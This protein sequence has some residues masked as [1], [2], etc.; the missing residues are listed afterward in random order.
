MVLFCHKTVALRTKM[1]YCCAD[2]KVST[3][4]MN[5]NQFQFYLNRQMALT[6][7]VANC[8]FVSV[9]ECVLHWRRV[10]LWFNER[11]H[12]ISIHRRTS[13]VDVDGC[14]TVSNYAA[15]VRHVSCIYCGECGRV[16]SCA[17]TLCVCV[18]LSLCK[19]LWASV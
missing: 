5:Y 14:N 10:V 11:R 2:L 6:E 1:Y 15:A 8:K 7:Q 18:L 12:I 4:L 19:C 3:A 17:S 13:D 16:Y 9:D